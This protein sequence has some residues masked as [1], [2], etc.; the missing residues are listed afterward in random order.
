MG[1]L[2][3]RVV[4]ELMAVGERLRDV[5]ERALL[6][7]SS[8]ALTRPVTFEPLVDVWENDTEVIVEAELPGS[9]GGDIEL[10]LEGGSLVLSGELPES[11]QPRG[12]YLRI[13][14]P[15]GRFHRLVSLPVDVAGEPRATLRGGVL[16]VRMPKAP[17]AS[18]RRVSIVRE[19]A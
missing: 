18:R 11:A 3:W 5:V 10:R 19:G 13:E 2:D 1:D 7:P 4:R 17:A 8:V 16:Q 12:S 15:R 9:R 6:P 14:R